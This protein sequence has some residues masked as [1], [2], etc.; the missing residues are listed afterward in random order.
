VNNSNGG[1]AAHG[2]VFGFSL[3]E[4]V[5]EALADYFM[6]FFW[7]FGFQTSSA[8][9]NMVLFGHIPIVCIF[10]IFIVLYELK[11]RYINGLTM[12]LGC[13]NIPAFTPVFMD[14][15]RANSRMLH[16]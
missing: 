7:D 12:N 13:P 1:V 15:K 3:F 6:R 2:T 9:L 5:C 8:L 11:S 4:Y 10:H 14:R 16:V